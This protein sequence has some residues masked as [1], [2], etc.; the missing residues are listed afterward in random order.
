MNPE[1]SGAEV[2]PRPEHEPVESPRIYIASLSDYVSGRLH[3]AWLDAAQ[4]VEKLH[5]QVHDMLERSPEPLAEEYALHDFTGFSGYEPAEYE[6]LGRVARIANGIVE[7]GPAFGAWAQ[8]C[9]GTDD[10]LDQFEDAYRGD[11]P[12][13]D[14]YVDELLDDLGANDL[15]EEHVPQWL[16]PYVHIDVGALG[17]DMELGG[18]IW[19][20]PSQEGVHV[21]DGT[22]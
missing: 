16:Q 19:T 17:R 9:D 15:I 2:P 7:H 12:S 18:D 4:P 5:E 11:W 20:S 21:F 1:Y 3:G 13:L 8:H 10:Q 22:L 6:S 14:A